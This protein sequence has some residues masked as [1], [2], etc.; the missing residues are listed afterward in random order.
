M[1]ELLTESECSQIAEI[2]DRRANDVVT[3]QQDVEKRLKEPLG[4]YRGSVEMAIRRE[5]TRLR[6]LADKIRPESTK[7]DEE[8]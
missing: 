2:L 1:K 4:D 5:V 7:D 6:K 8:D 3:F